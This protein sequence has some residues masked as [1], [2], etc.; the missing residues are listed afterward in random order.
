MQ[1]ASAGPVLLGS[2]YFDLGQGWISAT[3][4]WVYVWFQIWFRRSC[5]VFQL[6]PTFFF[7]F[8]LFIFI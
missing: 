6:N 3:V 8:Y 5:F 7:K 4:I 1:A 2:T